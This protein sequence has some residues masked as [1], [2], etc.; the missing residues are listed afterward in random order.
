ML[1]TLLCSQ[2][3]V[4][5]AGLLMGPCLSPPKQTVATVCERSSRG[6]CAQLNKE[7][8]LCLIITHDIFHQLEHTH[9]ACC[10]DRNAPRSRSCHLDWNICGTKYL[11]HKFSCSSCST[12]STSITISSQARCRDDIG[13]ALPL[14]QPMVS[15][16]TIVSVSSFGLCVFANIDSNTRP[17]LTAIK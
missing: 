5:V 7:R 1:P 8:F 14:N 6:V 17:E 13:D 4:S 12:L 3:C 9:C 11:L 10:H 15:V 2:V 16:I